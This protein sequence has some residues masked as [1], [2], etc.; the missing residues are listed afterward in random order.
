MKMLC[1]YKSWKSRAS[2][3]RELWS[4][5][6][7]HVHLPGLLCIYRGNLGQSVV[8][9]KHYVDTSLTGFLSLMRFSH[10]PG[11][12]ESTVQR[13]ARRLRH[14][15]LRFIIWSYENQTL[16]LHRN[17]LR[18]SDYSVWKHTTSTIGVTVSTRRQTSVYTRKFKKHNSA[19]RLRTSVLL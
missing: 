8:M 2:G 14:L 13:T 3:F 17:W 10:E 16:A 1:V 7:V 5:V 15:C 12:S 18:S 19:E 4:V 11:Q 9:W 6:S